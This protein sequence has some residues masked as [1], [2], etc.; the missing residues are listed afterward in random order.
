MHLGVTSIPPQ[1]LGY[2]RF[3]RTP[4]Y[5]VEGCL[6]YTP[7]SESEGD[8]FQVRADTTENAH[9]RVLQHPRGGHN[10]YNNRDMED[11]EITLVDNVSRARLGWIPGSPPCIWRMFLAIASS[12]CHGVKLTL[13]DNQCKSPFVSKHITNLTDWHLQRTP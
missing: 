9:R 5:F 6:Y 10:Y 2:Y 8:F 12:Y 3:A 11:N 4:L 7:P 13:L 1:C